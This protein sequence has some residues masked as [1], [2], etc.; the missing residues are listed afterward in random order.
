MRLNKKQI[1]GAMS[2]LFLFLILLSPSD[3]G[4]WKYFLALGIG[5]GVLWKF[6]K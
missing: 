4:I 2:L 3:S 1:F 6:S 5:F